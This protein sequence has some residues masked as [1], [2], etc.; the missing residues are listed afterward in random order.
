MICLIII[1]YSFYNMF[2]IVT[3]VVVDRRNNIHTLELDMAGQVDLLDVQKLP[4][5]LLHIFI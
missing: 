1:C 4:G 5:Y 2:N 3:T